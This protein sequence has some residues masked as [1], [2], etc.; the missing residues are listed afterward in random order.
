M[1]QTPVTRAA[2][3]V[4]TQVDVEM[5]RQA[6]RDVAGRVLPSTWRDQDPARPGVAFEIGA[7]K[8]SSPGRAGLSVLMLTGVREPG[9]GWVHRSRRVLGELGS[10][11]ELLVESTAACTA[12]K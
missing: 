12:A 2:T 3:T 1:P 4:S 9:A 6:S 11:Y 7:H 5:A 8:M 10:R